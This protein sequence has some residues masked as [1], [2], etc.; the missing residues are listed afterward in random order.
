MGK[1]RIPQS[2]H[3]LALLPASI[4]EYVCGEDA[5][6]YVDAVVEEFDLRE[7]ESRFSTVGR[8]AY[9]PRVLIKVILYGKL[10]GVRSSRELARACR[11]NLRFIFLAQDEKP[12]FRTISDFRKY[13]LD[14]LGSLLKQTVEIGVKEGVIDL[15]HV[16]VDGTK[17]RANASS[18]SFQKPEKLERLLSALEKSLHEDVKSEELEDEE[19]GEDDW[20]FKLPK[21]LQDK[22][23]LAERIRESL[24][25]YERLDEDKQPKQISKTDGDARFMKGPDGK[26]VYYNAQI[27]VDEKSRMAVGARVTNAGSDHGELKPMINEIK[28]TA[29][30]F[31]EKLSAD[32][33]Y[34]ATEGIVALEEEGIEGFVPLQA[35]SSNRIEFDQ[36]IYDDEYDE[37]LCP[38]GRSL[39]YIGEKPEIKADVYESE[40]CSGCLRHASCIVSPN[41]RRTLKVSHDIGAIQR[42]RARMD[43]E[44]GKAMSR[45]RSMTVEVAF[46]WKK[47]HQNLRRFMFRGRAAVNDEWRFEAVALNVARLVSGRMKLE[48]CST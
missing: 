13:H 35:S 23:A 1:F 26:R 22:K 17:I 16:A 39:V 24:R 12:D 4:D 8:P 3:Q 25:E 34:R 33:G 42:M 38:E 20:E 10:R 44:A 47:I 7:L 9:Q 11:E 27:A 36:F 2:R 14:I 37:Y 46:A 29:G 21:R 5:V 48:A 19:Y 31:P 30:S 15:K 18:K 40:S 28:T 6:R 43:S 45:A 41:S 32:K